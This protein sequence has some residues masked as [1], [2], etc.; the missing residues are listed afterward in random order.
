LYQEIELDL[1]LN[2]RS[3]DDEPIGTVTVIPVEARP[4]ATTLRA[5]IA[6]NASI[7][8][9][10][11]VARLIPTP[12][13][14]VSPL[15]ELDLEMLTVLSPFA[16][17]ITPFLFIACILELIAIVF[18]PGKN[19]DPEFRRKLTGATLLGGVVVAALQGYGIA[20]YLQS[21]MPVAL[22]MPPGALTAAITILAVMAASCL[23][24]AGAN[25]ITRHGLGNGFAV[26]YGASILFNLARHV[27]EL[28]EG[29]ALP[30]LVLHSRAVG[31]ARDPR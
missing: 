20:L 14:D 27:P 29:L 30:L 31:P 17:G 8:A 22:A 3:E 19:R 28:V 1:V 7:V 25:A 13:V 18:L 2:G 6:L 5:R 11:V 10:Y 16:V 15:G 4:G 12:V 24:L 26:L 9:V 23:C 21:D